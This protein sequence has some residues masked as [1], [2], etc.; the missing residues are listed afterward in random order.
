MSFHEP[1]LGKDPNGPLV[2]VETKVLAELIA[3]LLDLAELLD[4][5]GA[6]TVLQLA[7]KIYNDADE[8]FRRNVDAF[9]GMLGIEDTFGVGGKAG[10]PS[11]EDDYRAIPLDDG[12][13]PSTDYRD[14]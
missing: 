8:A 13:E 10:A 2:E 6:S 7:H 4:G 9:R 1:D 3:Q 12:D 14:R 11:S 5:S